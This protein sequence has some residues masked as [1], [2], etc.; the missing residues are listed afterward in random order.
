MRFP[1]SPRQPGREAA[2]VDLLL[3]TDPRLETFETG[4]DVLVG[5]VK[6]GRARLN[7]ALTRSQTVAFGLRRVGCCPEPEVEHTARRVVDEGSAWMQMPGGVPCRARLV[8][9]AGYG[10]VDE[11]GMV[12]GPLAHCVEFITQRLREAREVAAGA[13]FKDPVLGLFVLRAKLGQDRE[14]T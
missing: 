8:A 5:E 4:V 10:M 3:G 9:F 7:P 6:E 11:P 12:T 13:R 1:H 14:P 2:P